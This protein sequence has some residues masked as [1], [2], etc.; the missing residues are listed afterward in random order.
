MHDTKYIVLPPDVLVRIRQQ[1]LVRAVTIPVVSSP[2]KANDKHCCFPGVHNS[3][4]ETAIYSPFCDPASASIVKAYGL[5]HL[6]VV[7][8]LILLASGDLERRLLL[9]EGEDAWTTGDATKTY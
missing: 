2:W 8:D 7:K 9:L 4:F 5:L 3:A 1:R 6:E